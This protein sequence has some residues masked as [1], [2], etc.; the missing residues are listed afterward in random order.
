MLILPW[1][2]SS[3]VAGANTALVTGV[4]A[5]FSNVAGLAFVNNTELAVCNQ[6]YLVGTDIQ[7]NSA[8]L[9]QAVGG[10]HLGLTVTSMTFGDIEITTEDLPEGGMERTVRRSPTSAS[11]TPRRSPTA[12]TVASRS[13]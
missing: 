11:A 3:G 12:S 7:L 6:Q 4:E 5:G 13:G 1:A 9:V 2:L 8:G 10:G